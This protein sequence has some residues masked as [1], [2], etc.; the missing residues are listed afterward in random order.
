LSETKTEYLIENLRKQ[1]SES[2]Q[3][4]GTSFSDDWSKQKPT[5][6]NCITIGFLVFAKTQ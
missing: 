4:Y 6:K 3:D 5:G 2:F 1:L